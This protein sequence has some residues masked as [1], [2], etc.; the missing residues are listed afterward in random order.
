MRRQLVGISVIRERKQ[1][2][3][4]MFIDFR[5]AILHSRCCVELVAE[6]EIQRILYVTCLFVTH[7]F[8]FLCN[9]HAGIP[10]L[11]PKTFFIEIFRARRKTGRISVSCFSSREL[12]HLLCIYGTIEAP[13]SRIKI[14]IS[15]LNKNGYHFGI[16]LITEN[17]VGIDQR[18][19]I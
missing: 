19:F 16:V 4:R 3:G 6:Q 11:F 17:D 8:L 18:G 2:L 15:V 13:I 10:E 9:V 1:T 14:F 12:C 7:R 5:D